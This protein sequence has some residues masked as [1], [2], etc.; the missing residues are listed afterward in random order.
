MRLQRLHLSSSPY[1]RTF[2]ISW[3]HSQRVS[4]LWVCWSAVDVI[5]MVTMM[6]VNDIENDY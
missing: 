5:F 6:L 4:P 1:S 2:A 3:P